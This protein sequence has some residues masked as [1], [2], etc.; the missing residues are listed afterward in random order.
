PHAGPRPVGYAADGVTPLPGE[1]EAVVAAY[2]A[3]LAGASLKGLARQ[4]NA[5]AL[6]TSRGGEWRASTVRRA[7]RNPRY[8]GLRVYQGQVIG[9]GTWEPL[10]SEDVWR[11]V[12]RVLADPSR[13][14]STDTRVRF[15][16]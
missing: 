16:L 7:L 14:T 11:A 9:E 12:D 3:I 6:R 8:A 15:L 13:R 2:H 5:A 4:W 1:A 10:V